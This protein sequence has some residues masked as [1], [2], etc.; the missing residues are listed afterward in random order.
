MCLGGATIRGRKVPARRA[1]RLLKISCG[2]VKSPFESHVRSEISHEGKCITAS[3]SY[4]GKKESI[5]SGLWRNWYLGGWASCGF[6]NLN[7]HDVSTIEGKPMA[8]VGL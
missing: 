4:R 3:Y 2:M 6:S 1:K 7:N 5:D 8:G